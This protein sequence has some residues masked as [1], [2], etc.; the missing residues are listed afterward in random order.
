VGLNEEG[1]PSL[2]ASPLGAPK[3]APLKCGEVGEA[4]VSFSSSS[5]T[6][7]MPPEPAP[8]LELLE[9]PKGL[10]LPPSR[11][12]N[13]CP[14]MVGGGGCSTSYASCVAVVGGE[15]GRKEETLSTQLERSS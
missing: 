8:S 4:T 14:D 7:E 6:F 1:G 3:P 13:V 5:W 2:G 9:A 12:G 10:P 15:V 11:P